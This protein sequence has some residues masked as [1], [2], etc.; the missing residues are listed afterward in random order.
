M[1]AQRYLDLLA[2][3][4]LDELQPENGFRVLYL[5][6]CLA[7][8]E[9]FD[10][11]LYL[12]VRRHPDWPRYQQLQSIGRLVDDDLDNLG[13]APTMIGR[14]RLDHLRW[15]LDQVRDGA[16]PGDLMECGVWRGGA[17]LFL[18]GYLAAHGIADRRVWVADS[19]QGVPPPRLPE[20][21]GLDLSAARYP[22]LAVPLDTV[23]ETFRRH[24]LL[25]RQVV[26][27]AGW[28]RDT[29]PA[30]PVERLALLRIDAD[31]YESTRDILQHL[32]GRLSPG[33][34]VI[35][36]DYHC[37]EPC[38]RAVDEFRLEAGIGEPLERIDWT[39]VWWRRSQR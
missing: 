37:I 12:D 34:F 13:F 39:A 20:D 15:C 27:L 35:V 2:A 10:P 5:R 23:R 38:R 9:R 19:F 3:S 32:Y 29:L 6:R 21:A 28:F 4:L 25:D 18:R 11:R 24:G 31:L 17:A 8:S 26:F 14:A 30:A 22:Q 7:G 36:D 1:P 16:I 33:G